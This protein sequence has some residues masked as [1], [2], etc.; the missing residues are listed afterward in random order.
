MPDQCREGE[1]GAVHWRRRSRRLAAAEEAGEGQRRQGA[2][3]PPSVHSEAGFY[4]RS[5]QLWSVRR[6]LLKPL[7]VPDGHRQVAHGTVRAGA[8]PVLLTGPDRDG[9]PDLDRLHGATF[10]LGQS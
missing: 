1:C 7:D 2:Q 3:S 6:R 10:D 8:V 4:S 5:G 9:V